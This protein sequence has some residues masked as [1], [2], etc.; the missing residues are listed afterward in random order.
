MRFFIKK[1]FIFLAL[2]TLTLGFVCIFTLIHNQDLG[3]SLTTV[4]KIKKTGKL[5]LITSNSVNT[6]YYYEGKHTGF[7]YDLANAFAEFMNVELDIVTP[8]W[9]N[10][11]AYLDQGKGD[12]IAAG[13]AI[14]SQR[15]ENADFSIPYMTIQQRIGCFDFFK[16]GLVGCPPPDMKGPVYHIGKR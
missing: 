14:T 6:Y 2:I 15:L 4:E 1:H 10:M 12:F 3:H 8:G 13:L 7:E 5:R 9:N 16:P 11:F